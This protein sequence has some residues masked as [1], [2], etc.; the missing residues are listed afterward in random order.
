M[1]FSDKVQ[2]EKIN[3]KDVFQ[4]AITK[5]GAELNKS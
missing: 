1:K 2:E 4:Q 5:G 3:L